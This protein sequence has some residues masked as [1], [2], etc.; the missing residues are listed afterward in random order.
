MESV[1]STVAEQFT[2]AG[3]VSRAKIS[4]HPDSQ[5]WVIELLGR[6]Q[7]MLRSMRENPRTFAK[8]EA[9]MTVLFA[10]G[11]RNAEIDFTLWKP[12]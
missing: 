10:L 3:L 5:K 11:M 1:T 9:A 2:R 12:K 7:Y 8:P 6:G 4:W